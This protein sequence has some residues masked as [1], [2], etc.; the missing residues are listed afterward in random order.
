MGSGVQKAVVA[1]P[2]NKLRPWVL[3]FGIVDFLMQHFDPRTQDVYAQLSL[4]QKLAER[5]RK[6]LSTSPLEALCAFLD[7]PSV[8]N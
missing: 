6:S 4:T 8:G 7:L 2:Q 3:F 1:Q 5:V